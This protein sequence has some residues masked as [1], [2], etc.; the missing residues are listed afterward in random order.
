MKPDPFS[1]KDFQHLGE[2]MYRTRMVGDLNQISTLVSAVGAIVPYEFSGSG[3][4][5]LLET[6]PIS[7]GHSNY[8]TEFCH[9]YTNQGYLSDPAI[10]HLM[11]TRL[12][13]ASSEDPIPCDVPKAVTSLKLDFGIKTCLSS[14]VRGIGGVCTYFAFSNFDQRQLSKIKT[15][16]DVIAPH[17]HLGYLRCASDWKELTALR[18]C[19]ILTYREREIMKWVAEGKTNWEISIILGMSLN[20]LK[21]HLKNVFTKLGVENR[22]SAVARWQWR[23][24][25]IQI[26]PSQ[27]EQHPKQSITSPR[28]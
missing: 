13:V 17:F 7:V 4:V 3:I 15:V 5:N 26:P 8:P 28:I 25:A 27:I 9:L 11:T 23:E 21:W 20:T 12:P 10:Q 2:I 1:K 14:S 18:E 22:W 19:P 16:L 24:T 6:G